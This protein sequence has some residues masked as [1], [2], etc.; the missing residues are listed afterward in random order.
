[1]SVLSPS[2]KGVVREINT[3]NGFVVV[4]ET[5]VIWGTN[6]VI[7]GDG[8]GAWPIVNV[9]CGMG[10]DPSDAEFAVGSW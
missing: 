10:S 9:V 4:L 6:Q 2:L 7:S 5:A 3:S 8:G 1:M